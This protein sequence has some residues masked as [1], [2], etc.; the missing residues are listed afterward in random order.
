[1]DYDQVN[2]IVKLN[3]CSTSELMN[4]DGIG[5]KRAVSIIEHRERYGPFLSVEDLERVPKLNANLID[6]LIKKLDWSFNGYFI[7][8]PQYIQADARFISIHVKQSFDIIIT[9]PP[10][11]QKRDYQH[12]NQ[13]GLEETPQE[14]VQ[15]LS[16]IIDGWIPMLHPNASV[17][18]NV[19][20]TYRNSALIGIPAML[21]VELRNRGWLLVNKIIW[22][23]QN[24]VP[25]PLPYRLANR[26]EFIFQLARS[27][28][29]FSDVQ[30]LAQYLG[31]SANPGDVWDIPHARSNTGHLAPFPE[32]LVRRLI[33]FACPEHV[34]KTCQKPFKRNMEP[35]Y[36]LDPTR[37]QAKKAMELFDQAGLT[38]EHLKAIRAKGISDA[39]KGKKIQSGSMNSSKIQKLASEAKAVLGGYFREYTFS[40][41]IQVGWDMCDCTLNTRPGA[42]LDPFAGSGT[43]IGIA[44][45]LGR[46]A[47]GSDLILPE[48]FSE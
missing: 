42:L 37:P 16:N 28:D 14:Y 34:C 11:W 1:M 40:Q 21:E 7:S 2:K 19:G 25:E 20:D 33:Y 24:G 23:K 13:L 41:K 45:Q 5:R 15:H 35:T 9:S 29:F 3:Y 6:K 47:V 36:D 10:Y 4:L 32:E 43:S 27:S 44:Y 39:G 38:H 17:F 26:H 30:A 46:V 8:S 31:Q 12:P 22:S 48:S 18:I